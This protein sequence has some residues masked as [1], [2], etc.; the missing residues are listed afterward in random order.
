MIL[1]KRKGVALI[2]VVLVA[3]LFLIS[4]IGISAKVTSEK[5]ISVARATSERALTAAESGFSQTLFDLRNVDIKNNGFDPNSGSDHYLMVDEIENIV[6]HG[7]GHIVDCGE[8]AYSSPTAVPYVTYHV[9]IKRLNKGDTEEWDPGT[10]SDGDRD[11]YVQ[12]YSLGTVYRDSTKAEVLARRVITSECEIIYHK[13]NKS[14]STPSTSPVFD[15][16]V[17]SG[18]DINFNGNAQEV[19]G[20]IFA[21]GGIN[22]GNSPSKVRVNGGEAYA[23][24]QITGKG[25]TTDGNPQSG[26]SEIPFPQLNIDYY[27]DLAYKFK[28]GQAPY[29]GNTTG[30]PNTSDGI[31]AGIIQGYL[32]SD[33]TG[34]TVDEIQTFY[35]DLMAGTGGFTAL[36]P[37]QLNDLQTNAKSI[38]YFVNPS[39]GDGT[40]TA[41]INGTF[42]CQGTIVINGNLSINGGAE[43]DNG[44]GLAILVN[45]N[46]DRANGNATLNGLFYATGGIT[47]NGTFTC[48]GS[49]VTHDPIDLNGAFTVTYQSM[50][51]MPN[52]DIDGSNSSTIANNIKKAEQTESS[53]K[54][55]SYDVFENP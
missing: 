12:V 32:G 24:G 26:V 28:T 18:D 46:I 20:D 45:G 19:D 48:N 49:I 52:L 25:K 37:T 9:K 31:V 23:H 8:K 33:N 40:G 30:Y 29:D 50:T 10:G 15:Y 5:K 47:G 4:I 27:K 6:K 51:D 41:T 3:A 21:D 54:E 42:E 43:I 17:F 22:L 53:W 16:G 55:I 13:K 38:V 44:G 11:I 39:P 2:T 1:H 7:V 34:N 35:S 36:T 14:V